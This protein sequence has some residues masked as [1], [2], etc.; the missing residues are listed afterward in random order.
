MK[1]NQREESANA[2]RRQRGEN[3]DRVDK[4]LVQNP[5]YDVHGYQRSKNEQRLIGQRIRKRCRCAL[6]TC[7]EAGGHVHVFL[8]FVNLCNR[9]TE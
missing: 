2:C 4:A 8:D 7:L 3:R 1:K 9:A 5:K 6:K